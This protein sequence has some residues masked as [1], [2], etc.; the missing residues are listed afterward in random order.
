[1]PITMN[2]DHYL[3][4]SPYFFRVIGWAAGVWC[5]V[6]LL[7]AALL[8]APLQEAANPAI[9]PNPV[10]A[11][12]FLL[13]IQEVVSWAA[14]WVYLVLAGAIWLVALPWLSCRPTAEHAV[15]WPRE[16]VGSSLLFAAWLLLVLGLT[17][18]ALWFRGENWGLVLPWR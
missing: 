8:P 4:S 3:K 18:L 5:L 13:W 17:V 14:E 12:W 15:W 9:V 10:K 16:R 1:M 7:L 11:G 6:L 2:N